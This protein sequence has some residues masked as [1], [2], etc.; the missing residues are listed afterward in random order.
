MLG[1]IQKSCYCVAERLQELCQPG[2]TEFICYNL[3]HMILVTGGTGFIGRSLVRH[4][5]SEGYPIRI[6]MRPSQTS[7][8]LP[9]GVP[10]EVTVCS[11]KDERGL[12][13]AMKGVD[14]VYHLAGAEQQGSQ[15]DLLG[16]DI[17]G[18][19][20]I[21]QAAA[22]AG[23]QHFIAISHLGADRASAYP[24]LKA[25]AIAENYIRQSGVP[26][27]IIRSGW[28][29][30]PDD[31]FTTN[32]ASLICRLPG[33]FLLPGDGSTLVQPL[34]IEDLVTCLVWTLDKDDLRNQVIS[35]GGGEY[36]TFRQVVE[37]ILQKMGQHRYLVPISPSY[38]RILTIIMEDAAKNFPASI[39]WP[40]YL[41]ASRTCP[42]ENLP[43]LFGLLPAHFGQCLDY[44]KQ[45]P[46]QKK[47]PARAKTSVEEKKN[48][49]H[50]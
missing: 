12:R 25:K 1:S 16:V 11:L 31:H 6:L 33:F 27:T 29:F 47:T 34:W 30:G 49:L 15:A 10:V 20:A 37:T 45:E 4:L 32:L 24:V 41:A 9:Q 14:V 18:A 39:F 23:I 8:K 13:A 2:K 46:P 40:D 43:R 19:R 48:S 38:I 7:P 36:L 3:V 28:V 17:H 5:A 44:L 35:I 26:Y 21:S 22:D 42:V 50:G